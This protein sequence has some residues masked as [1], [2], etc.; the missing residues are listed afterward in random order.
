MSES[1]TADI[2]NLKVNLTACLAAVLLAAAVAGGG[3]W[4]LLDRDY[5][6][7]LAM[8]RTHDLHLDTN[9][10]CSLQV[11]R[12]DSVDAYLYARPRGKTL[13]RLNG[14]AV[15]ADHRHA[16]SVVDEWSHVVLL[17]G[18]GMIGYM[19]SGSLRDPLVLKASRAYQEP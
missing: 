17:D 15:C 9:F 7:Q 5:R 14:G 6:R 4:L 11:V 18:S 8:D 2:R 12:E 16:T 13:L 1:N 10:L 19:P 3:V